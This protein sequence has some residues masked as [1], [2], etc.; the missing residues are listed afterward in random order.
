MQIHIIQRSASKVNLR[1]E[2]EKM[3]KGATF[4]PANGNDEKQ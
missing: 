4:E 3:M 2:E 1:E